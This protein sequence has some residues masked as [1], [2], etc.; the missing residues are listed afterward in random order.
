M[1]LI[2]ICLK[3]I[4]IYYNNF[5]LLIICIYLLKIILIIIISGNNDRYS[6]SHNDDYRRYKEVCKVIYSCLAVLSFHTV[7]DGT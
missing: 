3:K 1:R 4:D 2:K 7:R 5:H 6:S